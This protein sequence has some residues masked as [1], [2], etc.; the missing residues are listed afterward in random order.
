[1]NTVLLFVALSLSGAIAPSEDDLRT[2]V[3]HAPRKVE[4]FI[5]RRAGCN[6]FAG[7]EP[8]DRERATELAKA[9]RDLRCDRIERDERKLRETYRRDRAILTLLDETLDLPDW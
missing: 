3:E 6:H 9:L 4:A 7:E 8:Y 5:I 1:M 2:R